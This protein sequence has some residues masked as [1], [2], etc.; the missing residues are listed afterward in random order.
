MFDKCVLK[1]PHCKENLMTDY[2][3]LLFRKKELGFK[4]NDINRWFSQASYS[5]KKQ[6]RCKDMRELRIKLEK[7]VAEI[8]IKLYSFNSLLKDDLLTL[9]KEIIKQDFGDEKYRSLIKKAEELR[10][11]NID[12]LQKNKK[13]Q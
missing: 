13:E 4:I 11:I 6:A 1:C 2:D 7:E 8:K 10:K 3:Y 9:L 5:D 12:N